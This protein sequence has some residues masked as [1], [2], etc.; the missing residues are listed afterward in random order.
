MIRG[1]KPALFR[2]SCFL[3]RYGFLP[4]AK[5]LENPD[6]LPVGFVRDENFIDP[7]TDEKQTVLGLTCAACHTGQINYRGVRIRIDGGP[8]LIGS[9]PVRAR[10]RYRVDQDLQASMAVTLTQC[11]DPTRALP[12][13]SACAVDSRN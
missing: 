5:G 4:D 1:D 3:E 6:G 13:G 12:T 2:E 10:H 9:K 8:A 11:L 7:F